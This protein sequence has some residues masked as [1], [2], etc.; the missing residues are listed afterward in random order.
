MR[1]AG[2][3]K[4]RADVFS[5]STEDQNINSFGFEFVQQISH[6]IRLTSHIE[7]IFKFFV[8][9]Y[10]VSFDT[11]TSFQKGFEGCAAI[12]IEVLVMA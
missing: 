5:R 11:E 8:S 4:Y 3:V 2:E 7:R 1:S 12:A 9:F 6:Q 10:R